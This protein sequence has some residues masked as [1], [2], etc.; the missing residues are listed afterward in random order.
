MTPLSTGSDTTFLTSTLTGK[1]KIAID[2][3]RRSRAS[4]AACC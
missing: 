3:A 2:K 4:G 1:R